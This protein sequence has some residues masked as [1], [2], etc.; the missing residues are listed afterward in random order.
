[1]NMIQKIDYFLFAMK[2]QAERKVKEFL[3][4]EN[5]DTNFISILVLLGIGLGLAGVF[6]LFREKIMEWVNQEIGSF[7][8]THGKN[9]P[10]L[11]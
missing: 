8:S 3:Y 1:M 4:N 11:G 2:I 6:M 10:V 7:F 5:G 9:P